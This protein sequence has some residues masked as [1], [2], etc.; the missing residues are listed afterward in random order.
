MK[1]IFQEFNTPKW[2]DSLYRK[3]LSNMVQIITPIAVACRSDAA[4]HSSWL[5]HC[6]WLLTFP[7]HRPYLLSFRSPWAVWCMAL[8]KRLFLPRVV[9]ISNKRGCGTRGGGGEASWHC[10]SLFFFRCRELHGPV[11]HPFRL[12]SSSSP[13][14]SIRTEASR[15]HRSSRVSIATPV[16]FFRFFFF[17][18]DTHG[19]PVDFDP[20][21]SVSR[22]HSLARLGEVTEMS[23]FSLLCAWEREKRE[24]KAGGRDAISGE[25][26]MT[27]PVI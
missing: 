3:L 19:R 23:V 4:S 11:L 17:L 25:R 5:S 2:Y 22:D 26:E 8:L 21:I 1:T 18:S 15:M 13:C 20:Q 27:G 10:Y 12:H 16:F 6:F 9:L 7:P 24:R 14:F